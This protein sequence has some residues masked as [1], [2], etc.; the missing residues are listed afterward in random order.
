M[1][2]PVRRAGRPLW[3]IGFT[4]PVTVCPFAIKELEVSKGEPS[5]LWVLSA[6]RQDAETTIFNNQ[7]CE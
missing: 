7:H 2:A 1:M 5:P 6:P 4:C 3:P